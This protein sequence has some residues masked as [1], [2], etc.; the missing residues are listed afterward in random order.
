MGCY[1]RRLQF[2]WRVAS[3]NLAREPASCR[4]STSHCC[5]HRPT[6]LDDI[7][8][9]AVDGVLVKDAEIPVGVDIH[10]ERFEFEAGFVG[11]VVQRDGAEIRQIRF[12][13]NRRVLWNFDGNFISLVLIGEGFDLGQGGGDTTFGMLL[14]V[15]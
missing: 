7:V 10:F 8:K 15:A 14:I 5:P 4:E 6:G 11:H 12:G 3:L 2:S 13:A 1:T 9:D